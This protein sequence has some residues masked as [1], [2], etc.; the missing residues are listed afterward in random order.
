MVKGLVVGIADID[1]VLVTD[2]VRDPDTVI[3]LVNGLV[4][5]IAVLDPDTVIDLVNGLVVGIADLE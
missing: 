5:G 4:V 1:R 3:D 2:T